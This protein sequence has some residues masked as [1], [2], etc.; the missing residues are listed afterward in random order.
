MMHG[1]KMN[2][3]KVTKDIARRLADVCV[4]F[5][6][7]SSLRKFHTVQSED[8]FE[9]GILNDAQFSGLGIF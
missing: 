4:L 9:S 6:Y 3:Q 5:N 8:D 1:I 2:E 7:Q